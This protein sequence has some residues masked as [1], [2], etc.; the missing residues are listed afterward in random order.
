MIGRKSVI[1]IAVLCA[2]ALSAF[3][4]AGA[5]AEQRAFTCAPTGTGLRENRE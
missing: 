5:N 2:L 4:A 3:A 1:G